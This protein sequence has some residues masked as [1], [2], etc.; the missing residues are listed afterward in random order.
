MKS[1]DRPERI[2]QLLIDGL[3]NDFPPLDTLEGASL[4]TET[5]TVLYT[6]VEGVTRRLHALPAN[7]FRA[8][9]ADY[10]RT[11][12][13]VLTALIIPGLPADARPPGNRRVARAARHLTATHTT[14]PV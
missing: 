5:V 13:R 14:R 10:H 1:L 6:D 2:F 12:E 7:Q 9:V 11:L 4:A 3:D 8:L